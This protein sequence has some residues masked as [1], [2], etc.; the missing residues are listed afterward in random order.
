VQLPSPRHPTHVPVLCSQNG[1]APE[2]WLSIV[3]LPASEP[4]EL[5]DE[6]PL[7]LAPE[8][9]PPELASEPPD[10]ELLA[11]LLPSSPL[12]PPPPELP[13][14]DPDVPELLAPDDAP[15]DDPLLEPLPLEPDAPELLFVA[16]FPPPSPSSPFPLL[17]DPPQAM[18]TPSA[19]AIPAQALP[20]LIFPPRVGRRP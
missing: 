16:S 3:Q 1:V 18:P 9:D 17:D 19:I 4:P 12:S 15:L 2:H 8:E 13:L 6:P 7:E 10:D 20:N 11:S 5:L 14:L